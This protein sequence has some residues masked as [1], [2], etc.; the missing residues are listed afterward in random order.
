MLNQT[1]DQDN[2][3]KLG[4]PRKTTMY[5]FTSYLALLS[6]TLFS[7]ILPWTLLGLLMFSPWRQF[8][9]LGQQPVW[10]FA[11]WSQN[12]WSSDHTSAHEMK[13]FL[14]VSGPPVAG[15]RHTTW[16]S[17]HKS[18]NKN[19]SSSNKAN[20]I[21]WKA[22][23]DTCRI[24]AEKPGVRKPEVKV[25]S[26]VRDWKQESSAT[27]NVDMSLSSSHSCIFLCNVP[28]PQCEP[29]PYTWLGFWPAAAAASHPPSF[30]TKGKNLLLSLNITTQSLLKVK[31]LIILKVNVTII[32]QMLIAIRLQRKLFSSDVTEAMKWD[33]KLKTKKESGSP[34]AVSDFLRP[35][36]L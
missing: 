6:W 27:K 21:Y 24:Q 20:G 22:I 9:W 31:H 10:S 8:H 23:G 34:S 4:L 30:I 17:L 15:D 32:T 3:Y 19:S 25:D 7:M 13:M 28:F 26:S 18:H 2:S 12:L 29:A 33:N 14:C 11:S 5:S 16:A 1:G 35:H 36:G